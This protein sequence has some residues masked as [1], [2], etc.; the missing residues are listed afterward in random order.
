MPCLQQSLAAAAGAAA[1]L[2][3]GWTD[4][5][6]IPTLSNIHLQILRGTNADQLPIG[7]TDLRANIQLASSGLFT[8]E[9]EA[10][11]LLQL[12]SNSYCLPQE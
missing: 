12:P 11:F 8:L 7:L 6:P 5:I 9:Q 1:R 4:G 2:S 10:N 3:D